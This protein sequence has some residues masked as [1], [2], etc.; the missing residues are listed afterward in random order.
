MSEG[1]IIDYSRQMNVNRAYAI[2]V[3]IFVVGGIILFNYFEHPLLHI[4]VDIA[5]P[6]VLFVASLILG[7]GSKKAIDYIPGEWEKRK[8]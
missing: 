6:G 1:K 5:L 7:F 4:I 3:S 2:I 8:T